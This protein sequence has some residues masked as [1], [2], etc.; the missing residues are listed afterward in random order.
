MNLVRG[1][2]MEFNK[3]FD[4]ILFSIPYIGIAVGLIS[5]VV[6]F[7]MFVNLRN[8]EIHFEKNLVKVLKAS[9]IT[10]NK[11][12]K[13]YKDIENMLFSGDTI[14]IDKIVRQALTE[15][16]EREQK[17]LAKGFEQPSKNGRISYELKFFKRIKHSFN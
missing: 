17:V 12:N 16:N 15:L 4:M 14:M 11:S 7:R 13:T 8:A 2:V 6:S 5:L 1:K 3:F 10:L 9:E